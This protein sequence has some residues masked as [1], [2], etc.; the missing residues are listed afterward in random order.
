MKQNC[1]EESTRVPLIIAG[2]GVKATGGISP[3]LVELIDLY[4]TLADL[5]GLKP[6]AGL[7]G[8]SLRPLLEKTDTPWNRYAY[9]QV[10]RNGFPGHTVR[11]PRWRYT[12]WDNGLK[13]VEL[14]DHERDPGEMHNLAADPAYAAVIAELKA[15]VKQNWPV[16][17][18]GGVAADAQGKAKKAKK[19]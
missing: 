17:V 14:Y 2:P 12:E 19:G 10:Q 18:T 7:A 15:A 9:T 6:P 5:S 8:V 3:R 13:G 4:P 1:Y 11:T 16:R